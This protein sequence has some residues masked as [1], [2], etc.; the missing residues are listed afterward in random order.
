MNV[1]E[2]MTYTT[3]AVS[4]STTDQHANFLP[5]VVEYGILGILGGILAILSIAAFMHAFQFC[6]KCISKKQVSIGCQLKDGVRIHRIWLFALQIWDL[7]SDI[8]LSFTIISLT[9]F[10]KNENLVIFALGILSPL[11]I[12]IPYCANIYAGMTLYKNLAM[13]NRARLYFEQRIVFFCFLV[14]ISGGVSASISLACSK[15]FGLPWFDCGLSKREL[16]QFTSKLHFTHNVLLENIPQ[17]IIQLVYIIELQSIDE[18]VVFALCTSFSSIV[19]AITRWL[20]SKQIDWD[21]QLILM[22]N[23]VLNSSL[24]Q[25]NFNIDRKQ[26]V[27][28]MGYRVKLAKKMAIALG[29]DKNKLEIFSIIPTNQGCILHFGYVMD[30]LDIIH[31]SRRKDSN[32]TASITSNAITGGLP[33]YETQEFVITKMVHACSDAKLIPTAMKDTWKLCGVPTV[34]VIDDVEYDY[35]HSA[36]NIIQNSIT[37]QLRPSAKA[38]P[39]ATPGDD[40]AAFSSE[41][42]NPHGTLTITSINIVGLSDGEICTNGIN[43]NGSSVH[44]SR[45]GSAHVG[46]AGN[47]AIKNN[48]NNNSNDKKRYYHT[49]TSAN[50]YFLSQNE[51][52]KLRQGIDI[53]TTDKKT[54]GGTSGGGVKQWNNSKNGF[55]SDEN[56]SDNEKDNKYQARPNFQTI[57]E[58]MEKQSEMNKD[59]NDQFQTLNLGTFR[60][61]D[62]FPTVY[63]DRSNDTHT[64]RSGS[65]SRRSSRVHVKTVLN[66][67]HD[68]NNNNTNNANN[69]KYESDDMAVEELTLSQNQEEHQ[70]LRQLTQLSQIM[71]Q[72]SNISARTK[73]SKSDNTTSIDNELAKNA[74]IAISDNEKNDNDTNNYKYNYNTTNSKMGNQN[75]IDKPKQD[76]DKEDKDDNDVIPDA[77]TRIKTW[78][79]VE[80]QNMKNK[81]KN[82]NKVENR[83][84]NRSKKLNEKRLTL[85]NVRSAIPMSKLTRNSSMLALPKRQQHNYNDNRDD[86]NSPIKLLQ[87]YNNNDVGVLK[88]EIRMLKKEVRRLNGNIGHL[89]NYIQMQQYKQH[90]HPMLGVHVQE[91]YDSTADDHNKFGE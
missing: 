35:G 22:L 3:E 15:I 61:G 58:E 1:F 63:S 62:T 45:T 51:I 26:C 52:S 77:I 64:P 55:A 40:G 31:G 83:N 37:P 24:S 59:N 80:S 60:Y 79:V 43:T 72:S 11:F 76:E 23:V 48:N 85:E 36:L 33:M 42:G 86:D 49:V 7:F 44:H 28:R 82:K 12:V 10:N 67:F 38:N 88:R 66:R 39:I 87:L 14:L 34:A 20:F 18:P 9:I 8:Y 6:P 90:Y 84:K 53:E 46:A 29:V 89:Q 17:L 25:Q 30:R 56:E 81:N 21:S 13:N 16:I 69:N 4:S 19:T 74:T 91:N 70:Q 65:R 71:T 75:I 47:G 78:D 57:L 2:N 50:V 32:V 68:N 73:F 5:T 41:S 27:Q 54:G